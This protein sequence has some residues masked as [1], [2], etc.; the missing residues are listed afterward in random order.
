MN[1]APAVRHLCSPVH[2]KRS[3]RRAGKKYKNNNCRNNI[4][5][6]RVLVSSDEKWYA[7]I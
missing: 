7:Y 2:S 6:I 1:Q 5:E 4:V 3:E